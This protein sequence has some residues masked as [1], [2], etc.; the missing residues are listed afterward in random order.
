MA[1]PPLLLCDT[2]VLVQLFLAGELRPLIDLKKSY[3]VQ[4]AVVLEVDLELRWVRKYRD[5]F[6]PQLDKALRSE[7]LKKLDVALFQSL[8]ASAKPG[9]SWASFQALGAQYYGYVQLGEAYTFAA[10]LSLAVPAAS[11]DFSAIQTLN[12][13]M[14]VLPA[15]IIRC[16]DLLVFAHRT[17]ILDMKACDKA[18]SELLKNGEGLPK[19]FQNSSFADGMKSF[20]CRLLD[21]TQPAGTAAPSYSSTLA[22]TRI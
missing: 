15:P 8:L 4:P 17:D 9:T 13:Q 21:G 19:P 1:N 7:T 10:G 16:F 11:N 6:V 22:I 18:R 12:A 20:V 3:G 2:D 5:R 14:L